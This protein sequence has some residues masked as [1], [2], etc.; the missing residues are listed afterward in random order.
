M[1]QP[2]RHLLEI[3]R[4]RER[5]DERSEYICLDRNER[6]EPFASEIAQEIWGRL[7]PELLC[8]YPDPSPLYERLSR[9]L[10]Y[11]EDW[12]YVTPG[13]DAAIRMLF[14][15]YVGVGDTVVHA[16]PT[17]AMYGI[18]TQIAQ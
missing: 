14:Q 3:Q 13:S 16:D 17:Y 2:R 10:G 6:V 4:V 18:Y 9:E 8:I 5:M 11:A 12:L 15:T 1:I 7:G